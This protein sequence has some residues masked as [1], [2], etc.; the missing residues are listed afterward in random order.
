MKRRLLLSVP[1]ALVLLT[2]CASSDRMIRN[3]AGVFAEYS[4][5]KESRLRS[6]KYQKISR[7]LDSAVRA[8]RDNVAG[9]DDTL[10][11]IWPFFFRS[12]NYWSA[13]WPLIDKDPY[14]FAFRPFYNHEGDDYSILFPL[15]A[16]NPADRNG[17]VTLWA[18]NRTGM[19]LLPLS[20]Q[21]RDGKE[22][23]GYYTPLC[24]WRSNQNDLF[25]ESPHSSR[26]RTDRDDY[27][28]FFCLAFG[29][30]ETS[31]PYDEWGWLLLDSPTEKL[32]N[33]WNYHFKGTRPF[34]ENPAELN[35][36]RQEVFNAI[37]RQISR[38][39]GFFPLWSRTADN[40]GNS[41]NFFLL[42]GNE[43][44][45][46]YFRW[47]LLGPILS[48]YEV[49]KSPDKIWSRY[50]EERSYTSFALM[51][52]FTTK[53]RYQDSE[54]RQKFCQLR[55]LLEYDKSFD[56]QKPA[57][58]DALK[59]L[60]PSQ[61]LPA[62]VK[63]WNTF[64]RF[65]QE[66]AA[67]YDF[68]VYPVRNG[69][70]VPLFS[71]DIDGDDSSWVL[72][73]LLTWWN[74][75]GRKY[76]FNSLPLMTFL[77]RSPAEDQSIVFSPLAY[78]AKTLRR[79]RPDY[80][81][82]HR[83]AFNAPERDC[84][85]QRDIYAACGL[86]YRGRF[87]FNIA[88]PG[89]DAAA[90]EK[91]RQEL[92]ALPRWQTTLQEQLAEI[93][94]ATRRTDRW[95][96]KGKIEQLKK[97]I[98]YEELKIE[99]ADWQNRQTKCQMRLADALRLAG[100]LGLLLTAEDLAD[101]RRADL[102][103]AELIDRFTEL[104]FYEDIGNGTFFHK[105]KLSNGDYDWHFCHL[106]AGGSKTGERVSSHILHFLYRYRQEGNRSEQL[107]FPFISTVRDGDDSRFSFLWRVFSLD[108]RGGKTGG[109]LFFVPFGDL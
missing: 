41:R 67:K 55:D 91:L 100:Q 105:Q 106:L 13:L 42:G 40:R 107:I 12:N 14:G 61:P 10:I 4:A 24:I 18:W 95:Q 37:P 5:P 84:A 103:R 35:R 62:T 89:V 16:W 39:S 102:K 36:V 7:N 68:P 83:Q 92:R 101:Q 63:D 104:R 73:S 78:Y 22:S 9:L 33:R 80:P 17:W 76:T 81:V 70:I 3:S 30:K 8:N 66:L 20:W 29:A 52:S 1:V 28:W 71:Y 11:N 59:K 47:H 60:D 72:P 65:L 88:K 77:S 99:R 82:F 6:E 23:G 31:V 85:E 87:G 32:R 109:Y 57:L 27:Y 64:E 25:Y 58:Q 19:G 48:S 43:Q 34:P 46:D 54:L 44:R 26:N 15:S 69:L 51:S 45:K 98:R 96:T 38:T 75:R 93:E 108:K 94:D 53:M 50:K 21:W 74:H 56:Q 86:F 79:S 97:L 2:G 49:E 90:V